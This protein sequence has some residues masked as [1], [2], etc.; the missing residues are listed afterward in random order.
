MKKVTKYML[1]SLIVLSGIFLI[2]QGFTYAKYVSSSVWNY[3]LK[4]K[5]FY[6]SS[7]DLTSEG[8]KNINN[9][10]DFES[11]YF[12]IQNSINDSLISDYDI[13]YKATCT[14]DGEEAEYSECRLNGSESNIFEGTLSN[15]SYCSN[16]KDDKDVSLYTK[17]KCEVNGYAW[18]NQ[19]ASQDLYFDI[20]ETTDK[21][22]TNL[23]VLI[24]VE[25]TSPYKKTLKGEYIIKVINTSEKAQPIN[26]NIKGA[27]KK[28]NLLDGE[29]ITYGTSELYKDN[30]LDNPSLIVPKTEKIS[31]E[32]QA[33]DAEIA[34]KTFV[35]YKFKK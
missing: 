35:I 27:G 12:K 26:I 4:S 10:W 32:G 28:F 21:E 16:M 23:K 24:E 15:Y 31:K 9:N 20:I 8:T 7:P 11:T 18:V 25:T 33:F 17:E 2:I 1:M 13:K 22:V 14:I 34:P 5:G 3:Y 6:F 29:M 19:V 30:T